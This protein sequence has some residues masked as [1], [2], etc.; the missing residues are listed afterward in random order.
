MHTLHGCGM[1]VPVEIAFTPYGPG[2]TEMLGIPD[3]MLV[4]SPTL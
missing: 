2:P 4:V 1:L 3:G